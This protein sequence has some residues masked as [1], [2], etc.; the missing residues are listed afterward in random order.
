MKKILAIIPVLFLG[1]SLLAQP[2]KGP[3]DKGM[4]FGEKTTADGAVTSD[5]LAA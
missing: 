2:P 4:T 3:A 5:E 1:F